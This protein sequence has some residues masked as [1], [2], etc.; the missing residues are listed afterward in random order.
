M[1]QDQITLLKAIV[2]DLDETIVTFEDMIR[3]LEDIING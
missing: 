2:K 1:T 3:G